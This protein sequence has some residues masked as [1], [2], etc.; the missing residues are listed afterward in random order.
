MQLQNVSE[1]EDLGLYGSL[2]PYDVLF[3]RVTVKTEKPLIKSSRIVPK[4]S[5]I[6]DPVIRDL[7]KVSGQVFSTDTVVSALMN[8]TR[9]V[10][11]FDVIVQKIGD[12]L[13]F[14][15]REN[16]DLDYLTVNETSLAPPQEL[17]DGNINSPKK[18]AVEATYINQNFVQQVLK[19]NAVVEL[20][21]PNPFVDRA[22]NVS[23][24]AYRYRTWNFGPD[25]NLVCRT[26]I[27]A[28]SGKKPTT[29]AESED[30]TE[31]FINIKALNEYDSKAA[32]AA[33]WRQKLDIQKGAI[34]ATEL[35]NNLFK[36]SRWCTEAFLSGVS[37]IRM[38]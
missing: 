13:F 31:S 20:D 22:E 14:Y 37:L 28:L 1:P 5:A 7:S 36:I 16:S 19:K 6:D 11:S 3:D 18:L 9:S 24:G 8:C 29:S 32:G 38:G 25:L 35:K 10:L 27:N 26:E 12:K 15:Q 23:S 4:V 17:G 33:D 30:I 2:E 21:N 34:F